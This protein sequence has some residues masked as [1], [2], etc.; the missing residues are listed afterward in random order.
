MPY[1]RSQVRRVAAATPSLR[2]TAATVSG[3]D[4]TGSALESRGTA[5]RRA[6][7]VATTAIVR[8]RT[9]ARTSGAPTS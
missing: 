9:V 7:L 8:L 1:R 4:G 2:A 5:P 3:A 6:R